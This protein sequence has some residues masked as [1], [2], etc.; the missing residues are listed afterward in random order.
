LEDLLD[1]Y[2]EIYKNWVENSMFSEETRNEL[3]GIIENENE[4]EDRFYR[5]LEFGTGGLRG[6]IGAGTNRMNIYTVGKATQGLVNYIKGT[7]KD[8]TENSV[9]VSYDSRRKSYEFA[10]H[11]ALIMAGNGI[12]AYLFKTLHPVP[13]LSF[14]VRHFNASL[15]VM[16]TASHNTKEYNGYK[17]YGADGAQLAVKDTD[18]VL[19]YI[20]AVGEYSNIKVITEE[21][22][23]AKG[24]LVMIGE[25]VDDAYMESIKLQSINPDISIKYG[26]D[27]V[28]VYTPIHGSG[29]IPVRRILSET[30]FS[31]VYVVKEQESPDP[32]FSTV[33]SPNPEEKSAFELALKLAAEVNAELVIATDPDCDRVGLAVRNSKK[34][35][36]MLSGNQVGCLLQEYILS[37]RT[38]NKT[39]PAKP[40]VVKTFVTSEMS[41]AIAE[42]YGVV[43][44]EV[45]TGF[46]FIGE[47]IKLLD[48]EGDM[49]YVFGFE[50][51]YGY[52]AGKHARDKDGVITSMLI[53]EMAAW[54]KSQNISIQE[55]LEILYKKY[56][57]YI[58]DAIS[59]K[60]EGKEGIAKILSAMQ[61]L[62]DNNISSFG[63]F[64]VKRIR[65]YLSQKCIAIVDNVPE[66][67]GII[68]GLPENDAIYYEISDGSWVCVR[69]SGT[70]P[71]I[72]IYMGISSENAEK[73]SIKLSILKNDVMSVINPYL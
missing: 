25:E 22:A 65:D 10:M 6:V 2:K 31:K 28:I 58:E 1:G 56:G 68:E 64:K 12:K 18:R 13:M 67:D 53:A 19:E 20:M 14:A 46:K 73:A 38:L 30:G 52:L 71:K 3:S 69:P 9:V 50:E 37:Q 63:G 41:R 60:L 55:G 7:F 54:Y 8:L 39:M 57:Y 48:D 26:S 51:S 35:Y 24:L 43:Q 16:I 61:S 40:F 5:E 4:I 21:D 33:K 66:E 42:K 32:E 29:N 70:E 59:V 23:I 45:L 27:V 34:G 11:T 62:R 15:G 72:K 36:D 44:L 47:K 49:N 17:V